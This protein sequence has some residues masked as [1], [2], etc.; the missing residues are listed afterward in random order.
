MYVEFAGSGPLLVAVMVKVPVPPTFTGVVPV[1]VM[2]SPALFT[3]IV[4][5]SVWLLFIG[6]SVPCCCCVVGCGCSCHCGCY[7]CGEC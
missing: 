6:V 4:L 7:W 5:S 1:L 2:V 3:C